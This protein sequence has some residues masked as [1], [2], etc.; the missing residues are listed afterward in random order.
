MSG[1][2]FADANTGIAVGIHNGPPYGGFI[3]RSTDGGET[4]ALVADIPEELTTVSMGDARTGVAVGQTIVR[5][6]DGGATW[7]RLGRPVSQY[8]TGV[9]F[10]DENT[11][12][13]V[14]TWG[15]ILRTTDGCATWTNQSIAPTSRDVVSAVSFAD[16]N[17]GIVV[18][19]NG[20]IL[21]TIDGGATWTRQSIPAIANL[22]AVKLVNPN[23]GTV[24]GVRLPRGGAIILRTETG[25]E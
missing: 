22:S 20:T 16:A 3:W 2:T 5:T 13:V 6:T 14:G 15:T 12:T 9:S 25:G 10:V 23:I 1:I 18:G 8:L 19:E 11:G 24:L 7:T 17:T 21:H 4:W